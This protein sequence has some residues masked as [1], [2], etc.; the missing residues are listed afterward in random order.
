MGDWT[1]KFIEILIQLLFFMFCFSMLGEPLRIILKKFCGLFGNLG[2]LQ[3]LVLDVYLGGFLL[4]I[5]AIIPLQLFNPIILY[6][7]TI[8]SMIVVLCFY[9]KKFRNVTRNLRL[10][11][12]S[13]QNAYSL[14]SVL[15]FMIFFLSLAIQASPLAIFPFGSVR[16]TAIHSLFTQALIENRQVPLTLQPYLDEGIIYPQGFTP[17]AAYSVIILNYLPPQAVFYLTSLLN[18]LTILGAY[19]LGKTLLPSH[20]ELL[21]LSLA[22]VFAFA[23]WWPKNITWG[24]N[25][26]VASFPLYLI[27]LSLFPLLIKD[28]LRMEAILA[29]GLLFGFLAVLHLQTYEMLIASLFVLWVYIV[30]KRGK[31]VGSRFGY[32]IAISVTSLL[33]LSPFLIRAWIFY[34][35]PY[36]N[37]GIPADVEISSPQPSLSLILNGIVW[38]LDNL[39][40]NILLRVGTFILFFVGIL[41]IVRLRK[42]QKL[43]ETAILVTLGIATLLGELLIFLSATISPYNLPF[44]PQPL[45]LYLPLYFFIAIFN[46][47]LYRF[48]SSFFSKLLARTRENKLNTKKTLATTISLMLLLGLYSPFLYQSIILD[49]DALRASYSIFS[50]TTNQ[51]LQLIL[52]IKENLSKEAI[53]LINNF[54]SGSFIP[55]IA[56]R[57]ALFPSLGSSY[58]ISYQK[59]VTLLEKK[60]IN[61]TT[62]DLLK[63]FNITNVFA[64]FGVSPW[65]DWRHWWNSNLF[66]GNPNFKLVKNFGNA[67][68]FQFNY[69]DPNIV[70]LEDF[71]HPRWDEN[72]WETYYNGN[73]L[74]N[75]TITANFG[76][77]SERCLRIRAQAV[78][79]IWEWKYARYI[80]REIYVHNNS[81]VTLSFYLNATEGFHSAAKDTF[82][83]L[84]SNIYNNQTIIIA[85]PN[86]VYQNYAHTVSLNGLEGFF[87]FKD[88]SSISN[89]WHQMFNSSLPN[90][91]ILE[92]VNYDFDGAENVAYIDNIKITSKPT[93]QFP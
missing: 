93:D 29:I 57:K 70:F 43:N 86:G 31:G 59:L 37:I 62:Y 3:I 2:L 32:F 44:Y 23:T 36:H 52:W 30:I 78:Y 72:G 68:L 21:G 25:A 16:D 19:F 92:F 61:A 66:L 28:K 87:E 13:F 15:V 34:K 88:N 39:A 83:V 60:V 22:F 84:I 91:F 50:V 77:N 33:V 69:T 54:Q 8:L 63:H 5:I 42:G 47:R 79:T 89:L 14:E 17:M 75:I 27:C 64:G 41:I 24:S 12:S 90:P 7:I 48:F 58:S 49:S 20:K 46:I 74:S 4:Y 76:H 35:Y 80:S 65:D 53:I 11:K 45:L 73:G 18:A 56:N 38:L 71:E 67:Y 55:S 81:D 51:D 82:A 26:F 1:L 40:G 9:W 85:T 10:K 6:A